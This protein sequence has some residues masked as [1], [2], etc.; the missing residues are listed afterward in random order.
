MPS[1]SDLDWSGGQEEPDQWA[2]Q[3]ELFSY[4]EM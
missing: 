1:I 3:G 4:S 2:V